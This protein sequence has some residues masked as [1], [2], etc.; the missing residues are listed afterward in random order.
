[1]N[2]FSCFL[3]S[4]NYTQIIFLPSIA[5]P[6]SLHLSVPH[7]FIS[8]RQDYPTFKPNHAGNE[9][10]KDVSTMKHIQHNY[11]LP[12]VT[13]VLETTGVPSLDMLEVHLSINLWF[14]LSKSFSQHLMKNPLYPSSFWLS[15]QTHPYENWMNLWGKPICRVCEMI[16]SFARRISRTL[17]L[18]SKSS[19]VFFLGLPP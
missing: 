16:L 11:I 18:V 13:S 9:G 4:Y 10:K 3:G 17:H 8:K 2:L 5:D 1:M 6:L 19:Q 15:R 14:N 7:L 12:N